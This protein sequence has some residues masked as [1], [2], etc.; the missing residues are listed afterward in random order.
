MLLNKS[1]FEL[2]QHLIQTY[3]K[4]EI[5]YPHPITITVCFDEMD[6]NINFTLY[7]YI[8]VPLKKQKQNYTIVRKIVILATRNL[9][10]YFYEWYNCKTNQHRITK[11]Q[12]V[13]MH[14]L[15]IGHFCSLIP[16]LD[17][18]LLS[19]ALKMDITH[20]SRELLSH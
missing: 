15:Q 8:I 9:S 1:I 12:H 5:I 14:Q 11:Y 19:R 4:F 7:N 6:K 16:M 17:P 3:S 2:Y 10:K 20:L 18:S 13:L